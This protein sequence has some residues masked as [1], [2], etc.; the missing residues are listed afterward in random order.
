[1]PQA[2]VE[3]VAPDVDLFNYAEAL[4]NIANDLM[5]DVDLI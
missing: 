3:V 2:I 5:I 4:E 1:M